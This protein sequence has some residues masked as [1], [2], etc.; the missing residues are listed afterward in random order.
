MYDIIT[1]IS[2]VSGFADILMVT[3]MSLLGIFYTPKMIERAIAAHMG[4]VE[5]PSSKK[6]SRPAKDLKFLLLQV[7][8]YRPL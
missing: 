4:P 5:L 6:F 7:G 2:E 8:S 1:L 3:S